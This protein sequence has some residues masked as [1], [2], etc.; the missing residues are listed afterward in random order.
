[1]VLPPATGAGWGHNVCGVSHANDKANAQK[2]FGLKHNTPQQVIRD[3]EA[4]ERLR[5]AK[6]WDSKGKQI[7]SVRATCPSIS[8]HNGPAGRVVEEKARCREIGE[9]PCIRNPCPM[10]YDVK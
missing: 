3:F 6:H 7:S 2:P 8:F 5:E 9:H 1:M 4:N 10:T